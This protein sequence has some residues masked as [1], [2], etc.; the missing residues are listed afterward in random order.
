M[1]GKGHVREDLTTRDVLFW[2]VRSYQIIYRSGTRPLEV[3]A[4]LHGKRNLRRILRER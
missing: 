3:V 4:V 2:P 1:P